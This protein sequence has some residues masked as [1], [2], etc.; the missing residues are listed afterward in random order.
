MNQTTIT[1]IVATA[2]FILSI[3][4]ALQFHASRMEKYI[5]AKI[6]GLRGETNA[7]FDGAA[8]E[9]RAEF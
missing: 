3:F 6:E 8:A 2:A 7:R 5:E 1:V 9:S 4:G